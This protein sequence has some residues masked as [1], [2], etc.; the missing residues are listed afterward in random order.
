MANVDVRAN[1]ASLLI[2]AF[3]LQ[4]PESTREENDEL[5][6]KQITVLL[7]SCTCVKL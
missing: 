5:I 4:N 3:P 1:A 7:V 6:Q 2:D